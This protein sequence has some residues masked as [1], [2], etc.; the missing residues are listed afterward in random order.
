MLQPFAGKDTSGTPRRLCYPG[1]TP[2]RGGDML[3]SGFGFVHGQLHHDFIDRID[4]VVNV[5]NT[6]IP[7]NTV[8]CLSVAFMPASFLC[9]P[10]RRNTPRNRL[11]PTCDDA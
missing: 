3:G 8:A 10:G 7:V 5:V 6:V 4:L 1:L 11:L 9:T 2:Q